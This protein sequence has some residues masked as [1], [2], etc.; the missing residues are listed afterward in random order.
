M[1]GRFDD[2]AFFL[3]I[4]ELLIE[5][6][7]GSRTSLD[8]VKELRNHRHGKLK[9]ETVEYCCLF[10]KFLKNA[11]SVADCKPDEQRCHFYLFM[12]V[13]GVGKTTTVSKMIHFLA[14][15]GH[16]D[17]VVAAADT[18][19]AAAIEQLAIHSREHNVRLIKQ[20]Y[21]AD[22]AAVVHDAISSAQSRED[23]IIITDTAG[24]MHTR[25]DLMEQLV[26]I[27]RVITRTLDSD[28]VCYR[29]LVI[30]A[31]T[32]QNAFSQAEAFQQALGVD[33][34]ILSKYDSTA[35]GGILFPICD[36]LKIPV[37]Y[38]G[39]GESPED[40]IEFEPQA[41]VSRLLANVGP[42]ILSAGKD[43]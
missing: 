32:G 36:S 42:G 28:A 11:Y 41:Y 20:D 8:I 2:E 29:L 14:A 22:P 10:R 33:A 34:L 43:I 4:E 23:K 40:L 13:N 39:C 21:G 6:D 18:F 25:S 9:V 1:Q 31:T 35:G 15:R 7:F 17:I 38:L 16:R 12:G 26:K 24:R 27:N 37:A 5:S 30:D 19:R 3:S